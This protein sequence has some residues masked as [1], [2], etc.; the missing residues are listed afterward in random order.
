MQTSATFQQK[1]QASENRPAIHHNNNLKIL[2][3]RFAKLPIH[4]QDLFLKHN[5]NEYAPG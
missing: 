4:E 1:N 2:Q 5:N 3:A